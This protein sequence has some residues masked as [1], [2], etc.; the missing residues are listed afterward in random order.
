M[1]LQDDASRQ[2]LAAGDWRLFEDVI[3]RCCLV[4]PVHREKVAA[5]QAELDNGVERPPALQQWLEQRLELAQRCG[6]V[7]GLFVR[8]SHCV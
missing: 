5:L 1:D 3:A 7:V 4:D 6:F 8:P 2:R